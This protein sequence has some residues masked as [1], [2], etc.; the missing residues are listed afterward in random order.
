M[1]CSPMKV[2]DVSEEH[3]ASIFLQ[4]IDDFYLMYSVQITAG[5]RTILTEAL[6][7]P[8]HQMPGHYF[9]LCHE[10]FL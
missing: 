4:N 8:S 9:Q 6:P 1:S 2:T 3:I 5:A 10:H 7:C